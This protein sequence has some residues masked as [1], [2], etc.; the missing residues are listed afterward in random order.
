MERR[1]PAA[2]C[3]R[4]TTA[5]GNSLCKDNHRRNCTFKCLRGLVHGWELDLTCPNVY[6]HGKTNHVLTL[7]SFVKPLQRQLSGAVKADCEVLGIHGSRGALLKA[8]LSSHG[9]TVPAK[10]TVSE[11]REHLRHEAAVYDSFRPI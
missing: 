6:D 2:R 8:T 7:K 5:E 1:Q 11:P 9:Y 4:S 3:Q 10:C